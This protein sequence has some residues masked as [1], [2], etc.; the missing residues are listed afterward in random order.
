MASVWS[1]HVTKEGRTYYYNR[2]T[3]QSAW[4]KPADFDGDATAAA[5]AKPAASGGGGGGGKKV[6]WEELWDPKNERA[7]YYN[8]ATRKTQWLRPEHVEIKPYTGG[9]AKDKHHEKHEKHHEK[10]S[11]RK[12]EKAA[13]SEEAKDDAGAVESAKAGE[14]AGATRRSSPSAKKKERAVADQDDEEATGTAEQEEEEAKQNAVGE[15]GDADAGEKDGAGESSP[16]A[17]EEEAAASSNGH[18]A[19]VAIKKKKKKTRRERA[20]LESQRKRRRRE[21]EK[22]L[23]ICDDEDQLNDSKAVQEKDTED[24]K[25][26]TRLL[27]ELSKTDAIMEVNVLGVINGFL[28]AHNESNGPEILVEK[29]SSS[30]RG[31]AQMIGLVGSWLD[32][33]PVSRTAL[34]NKVTFDVSE[35]AVIP[36][37]GA[38]WDPAEEILYSHLKDIVNEHYDPKLVSNVLSGSAAEPEWLTQML[39]D[40]KW[41][42]MLI[43]LA[44]THKVCASEVG[45]LGDA[46]SG[47]MYLVCEWM[48]V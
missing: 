7:Y 18:E 12:A 34:E 43:E 5:S 11:S 45:C 24:G 13:K 1:A 4:E 25:E 33:L 10:H 41:R 40:R 38:S 26:A 30:Y 35:G 21:S 17:V 14:Q 42:L 9:A 31:H 37:K 19:A 22:R 48:D 27:Q 44:E 3:K 32:L 29:L 36:N 16:V 6:E 47:L 23:I 15:A 2:S 39:N 46:V 20:E 28:R 8:R